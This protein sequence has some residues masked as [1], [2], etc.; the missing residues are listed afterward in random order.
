MSYDGI[1][2]RVD[3]TLDN[4]RFNGKKWRAR[5]RQK[6]KFITVHYFG[7]AS[8]QSNAVAALKSLIRSSRVSGTNFLCGDDCAIRCIEPKTH[9]AYAV[10]A[11][12]NENPIACGN[13]NSIAVDLIGGKTNQKS[14]SVDDC[15]WFFTQNEMH[16][17]V[18]VIAQ[19][20]HDYL[21][22]LSCV[23]RHFDVT[24]KLCPRPFTGNDLNT[25]FGMSG[26]DAWELF[27]SKIQ[28][29]YGKRFGRLPEY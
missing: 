29:E 1:D 9:S 12:S 28:T 2:F 11:I 15:D 18:V 14:N 19:L 8:L 4:E 7:V 3:E 26:N 10:G 6:V 16:N 5:G 23:V 24:R 17:G 27:K 22:P 20:M 25:V 13:V 21:I